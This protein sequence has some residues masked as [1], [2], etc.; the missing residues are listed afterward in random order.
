MG[1]HRNY[2]ASGPLTP[3]QEMLFTAT[4]ILTSAEILALHTTPVTLVPAPGAN[5]VIN[6]VAFWL[7]F[8][9]STLAY[10][11]GSAIGVY[12]SG[13]L[14]NKLDD[15]GIAASMLANLDKQM[16]Q[17]G[18]LESAGQVTSANAINKAVVLKL[19]GAAFTTGNGQLQISFAYYVLTTQ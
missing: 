10:A 17:Y 18:I 1:R 16:Q 12:Y 7:R 2:G 5:K 11:G 13:D 19:T 3:E 15:I 4:R 6:G 9:P 8:L 14:A